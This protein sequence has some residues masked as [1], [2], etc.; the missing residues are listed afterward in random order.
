MSGSA[1]GLNIDSDTGI[2][3]SLPV[4]GPGARAYAFLVD[5]HVRVILALAWFTSSPR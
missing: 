3:V 2:D 4:A 5:W 1:P